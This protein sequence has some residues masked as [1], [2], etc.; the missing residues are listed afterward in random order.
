[1]VM[2]GRGGGRPRE[3]GG[4]RDKA[5]TMTSP[6]LEGVG[7]GLLSQE[8]VESSAG[9]MYKCLLPNGWVSAQVHKPPKPTALLVP[10]R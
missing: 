2:T 10:L 9:E 5:G 7:T 1:M 3:K 4:S 8:T 6:G